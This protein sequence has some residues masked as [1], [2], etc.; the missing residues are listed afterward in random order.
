MVELPRHRRPRVE[1]CE[2]KDCRVDFPPRRGL[3]L[4]SD[5]HHQNATQGRPHATMELVSVERCSLENAWKHRSTRTSREVAKGKRMLRSGCEHSSTETS[6]VVGGESGLGGGPLV[7]AAKLGS[8]QINWQGT[9]REIQTV[10]A[11]EC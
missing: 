3:S 9:S 6:S 2:I 10:G 8:C 7:L 1:C 4:P 5:V 11:K